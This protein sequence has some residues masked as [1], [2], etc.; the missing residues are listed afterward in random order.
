MIEIRPVKHEDE[1]EQLTALF[2]LVF[3]IKRPLK[4][5]AE[6]W[7]WKYLRHPRSGE[8]PE[9]VVA[10]DGSKVV[11]ARPFMLNELWVG[12]KKVLAAQHCDTMVHPDYRRLGIFNRM[13][14]FSKRYLAEHG[15][16]LSYGFPGPMSRKGFASQGY[17]RMMDTEVLLR[18]VNP[19]AGIVARF[20]RDTA[21][22]S[23]HGWQTEVFDR[24]PVELDELD[25]LR[26]PAVIDMVR[27]GANLRWRFDANPN[28]GYRYILAKTSG[29]LAGYAVISEQRQHGG[30]RAGL[31]VDFLVKENYPECFTALATRAMREFA[32]ASCHVAATWAFSDPEFRNILA[33]KFRFGSS[34]RFPYKR[35][36]SPGYMDVLRVDENIAS[37]E[38]IYDPANWRVTYAYP[39]FI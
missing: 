7:R 9:V 31:L 35:F 28:T 37:P 27:S 33:R 10:L 25:S 38:Y 17:R 8:L 29:R 20:R 4:V 18:P 11:G 5:I 36:V 39:N 32:C 23:S 2:N 3:K 21:E 34:T 30:I 26:N 24:Y 6:S 1:I 15:C 13:G 19:V 14:E 12:D 16:G 22:G